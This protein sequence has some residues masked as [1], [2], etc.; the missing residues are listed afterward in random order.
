MTN[1]LGGSLSS[2]Q[3][4]IRMDFEL[5]FGFIMGASVGFEIVMKEDQTCFVLDL[6]IV[7]FAL[8]THG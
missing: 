1:T 3:L 5:G 7:R 6:L 4:E 2:P 8:I